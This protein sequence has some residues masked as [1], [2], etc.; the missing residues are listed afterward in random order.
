[1]CDDDDADDAG[2]IYVRRKG[3]VVWSGQS[4]SGQ[5]GTCGITLKAV[6]MPFT[7]EGIIPDLIVNPA[8]IPTRMTVGQLI[9]AITGKLCA[10]KGRMGDGTAFVDVDIGTVQKELEEN[11]YNG[12]GTEWLYNGMTG[13]KMKTKI[14]ICPTFYERLKHMVLDKI[15]CLTMDHE[16]LTK[17]GFKFFNQLSMDDKIA[18]LKDNKIVYEKPIKLLYYPDFEGKLYNI[19]NQQIDLRVTE[20]HRMWVSRSYGREHK[21]LA[22]DFMKACDIV[23]KQ[24]RYKKDAIN[25]N[26]KYQFILPSVYMGDVQRY[27]DEKIVDMEAWLPFFGIWIAEGW[28]NHDP[29][30][31]NH[32]I[33][34]CQ[35]K[36]R[37]RNII[38]DAITKLGYNYNITGRSGETYQNGSKIR[39]NNKQLYSY[40]EKLSVGAPNKYLP[41]WVWELDIE[42]SRLL[43]NSLI[44]GDGTYRGNSVSYYTSSKRLADDVMRLA[45]HAGWSG[46]IWLHSKKGHE[47]QYGGRK[48][49]AKHDMYRIGINKNKNNPT[50]NHG[51]HEKQ[52]IQKEFIEHFKEPVF[53]LEV[54]SEVFY[55]RRNGKGVWT[56]NSRAKG[57]RATLTRQPPEGEPPLRPIGLSCFALACI[58]VYAGHRI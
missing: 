8:A 18:T 31:S 7:K 49:T 41:D 38:F 29:K 1:V 53:C 51:H 5:K 28:T 52:N 19:S 25:D 15:H 20:D 17:D 9:E 11:G 47:T 36:E 10:I 16:V 39:I 43:L 46:N 48:I 13:K 23:G 34:I 57:P 30:K 45:L 54:P 2:I 32:Q 4:R 58:K 24:V 33:T 50:V 42:Q 55:V 12:D 14:F 26:P 44:I 22:H 6:D 37:V 3:V 27:T 56:G 21:W 35:C 40:L